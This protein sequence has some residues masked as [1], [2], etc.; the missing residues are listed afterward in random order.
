MPSTLDLRRRIRSVKN[1]QQITRAMKMVA[2]AKLRRAQDRMLAARPYSGALHQM[3]Q[4]VASRVDADTHPLLQRRE[5]KNVLLL[6]VTAD[7]GLAGAFNMNVI[8]AAQSALVEKGWE[9]VQLLPVGRKGNDFF[10]R[11]DTAIRWQAINIFQGLSLDTAREISKIIIDDYAAGK[12]DAVYVLSN[13][14]RSMISQ[15][16]LMQRML[17]IDLPEK[18]ARETEIEY[19]YEPEPERILGELLPRYV[20]FQIYRILLESAAA[21]H[22]ARMTAME[23]ATKNAGDMIDRLTLT[24]NRVRQAAITKEIIE[25]VSGASA[26]G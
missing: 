19:I 1:T 21:E 26:M 5:E 11:R 8:K 13:E 22:A 14:F 25:I 12:I 3:L 16:V 17:P 23:A 9:N 15:Q 2:A 10:R 6:V 24:Y 7:K 4:S 18:R 20:E